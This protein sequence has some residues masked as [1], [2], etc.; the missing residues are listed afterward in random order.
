MTL[1]TSHPHAAQT[2]G[3]NSV[4]HLIE[5]ILNLFCSLVF[6]NSSVLR[7]YLVQVWAGPN[8]SKSEKS[9]SSHW[10]RVCSL[11]IYFF[12][13]NGIPEGHEHIF[14]TVVEVHK[15]ITAALKAI[16][17]EN[18]NGYSLFFKIKQLKNLKLIYQEAD[19]TYIKKE[20]IST[21][22]FKC[23]TR[24]HSIFY[25]GKQWGLQ[26]LALH[27][28]INQTLFIFWISL[29]FISTLVAWANSAISENNDRN[30]VSFQLS[31]AVFSTLQFQKFT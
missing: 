25:R 26:L 6:T 16:L 3:L 30:A 27:Y 31:P 9:S 12:T 22:I 29:V 4:P 23:G 1:T 28:E 11:L 24:C 7:S 19:L 17:L 15:S 21:Q 8:V 13:Y 18:K 5:N 20:H 10:K 2:A 14:L